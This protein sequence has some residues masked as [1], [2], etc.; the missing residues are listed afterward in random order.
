MMTSKH[1][2]YSLSAHRVQPASRLSL[3]ISGSVVCFGKVKWKRLKLC[4][5]L[6]QQGSSVRHANMLTLLNSQENVI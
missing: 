2:N 3:Q 5:L 4:N 6:L 1:F